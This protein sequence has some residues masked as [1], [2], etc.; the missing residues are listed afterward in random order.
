[1]TMTDPSK[2]W[3]DPEANPRDPAHAYAEA[4]RIWW[5][6]HANLATLAEWMFQRGDSPADV[7]YML[8]KPW[9]F[10]DEFKQARTAT[11]EEMA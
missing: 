7:V 6:N 8:E 3:G 10:E 2:A 1:M 4:L 11:E 9:K 5:M